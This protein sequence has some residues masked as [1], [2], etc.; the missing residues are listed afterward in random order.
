MMLYRIRQKTKATR[1]MRTMATSKMKIKKQPKTE[2]LS[3]K[4]DFHRSEER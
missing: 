3:A 1:T 4:M 2:A